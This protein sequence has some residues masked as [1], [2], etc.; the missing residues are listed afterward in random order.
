MAPLFTAWCAVNRTTESGRVLGD[1]QQ[2]SVAQAL[3]CITLGAAHVLKLDHLVGSIQTGKFADF[4]VLE[5]DPFVVAPMMLKDI[6]VVA[7][8]L[9]GSVTA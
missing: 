2:I 8:V 3:H 5:E 1:S 7:T 4:C 6:P 9:G